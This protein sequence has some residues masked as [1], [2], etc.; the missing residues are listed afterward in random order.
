MMNLLRVALLLAGLSLT[1]AAQCAP[2]GGAPPRRGV[3]LGL[4]HAD[5]AHSYAEDL[6]EIRSLG[7]NAVA[8][9]LALMQ[10]NL[11]A[12]E[13]RA[14]EGRTATDAQLAEAIREARAC[15]L[16]VLVLPI[17]L[18]ER[19]APREWRGRIHPPDIDAWFMSYRR[20]LLH[21]ARLAEREG[22][23]GLSV[24]S[25]LSTLEAQTE[26]WRQTIGAVRGEFSGW[27]TY[28]VNWD[29]LETIEFWDEL[30][31]VG[32]SSY[33]ELARESTAPQA[34]LEAAWRRHRDDL[35][36]WRSRRVPGMPL[37]LTEVGYPSQAS[38]PVHPWSYNR[39]APLDLEAQARCY[40]AL[41]AAWDGVT[42]L[43]GLYFYEWAGDGGGPEDRSYTPQGKPAEALIRLW[44]AGEAN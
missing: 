13:V 33:F 17:V 7:A 3:A 4:Y 14:V 28:S 39:G 40:E 8:L 35:L 38:A 44:Y 42:A 23:Q 29:H 10:E 31:V 19:A 15:G 1:A 12:E 30:D 16:E 6:H 20:R 32:V 9:C 21:I 27:L 43:N 25:E 5:T 18:L 24:G 36:A 22:A 37:V 2:A 11:H 34:S 26:H 41:I